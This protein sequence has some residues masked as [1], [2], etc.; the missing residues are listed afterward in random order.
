VCGSEFG[1][2]GYQ[3]VRGEKEFPNDAHPSAIPTCHRG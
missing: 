1:L 3:G 2:A